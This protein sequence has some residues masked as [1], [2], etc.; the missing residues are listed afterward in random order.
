MKILMLILFF[1]IVN[2]FNMYSIIDKTTGFFKG[3]GKKINELGVSKNKTKDKILKT[4][5]VIMDENKWI[6]KKLH[7]K[8][9]NLNKKNTTIKRI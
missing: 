7:L 4:V 5:D 9:K 3:I 8:R 1:T 2:G 6:N